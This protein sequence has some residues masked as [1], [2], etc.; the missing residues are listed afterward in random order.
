MIMIKDLINIQLYM[1]LRVYVYV[2]K[3]NVMFRPN[4]KNF[5]ITA[6]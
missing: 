5:I 6:V 4:L 3:Q 2:S 1:R